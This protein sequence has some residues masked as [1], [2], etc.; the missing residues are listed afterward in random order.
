MAKAD[1]RFQPISGL[2]LPRLAGI[3]TTAM[4]CDLWRFA[5]VP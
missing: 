3:S 2:T 4:G 1:A 5:P